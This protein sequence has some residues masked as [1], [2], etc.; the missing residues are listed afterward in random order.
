MPDTL[1]DKIAIVT[2]A[3]SGIGEATARALA[4]AGARVVLAARRTDR[5]DALR[6]EIEGSGGSA[7]AV[8]T[9]VTDRGAVEALASRTLEAFGR[10]DILINNAG[11]MLLSPIRRLMVDEWDRMIEVNVRGALYCIAS[12][13]PAMLEQGAGH[14]VNVSSVA[15]RRPMPS[16]TIY[17]ATK[18]ALRAVSQGIHLE[19]SASDKIRVTDIEPGVVA[20]ELTDHITDEETGRRF[21]ENWKTKEALGAT[22][23][24]DAILYAVGA[25]HRVNVNEILVRPTD[26]AT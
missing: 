16:G 23:V 4:G 3:S 20:T 25:P 14:I 10:I 11:I 21:E 1:Q 5:L 22:D 13:L 17:S 15:G 8:T 6:A 2:G 18:F 19:L 24:A 9:D 26:Q 7:L 12:V